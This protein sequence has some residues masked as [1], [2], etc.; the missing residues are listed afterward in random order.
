[1]F[2]FFFYQAI[3]QE[4]GE[5]KQMDIQS[6]KSKIIYKAKVKKKKTKRHFIQN[7]T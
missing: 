5:I 3:L 6:Y 7:A 1:M 4:R 2:H